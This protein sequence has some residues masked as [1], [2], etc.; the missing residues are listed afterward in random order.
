MKKV[1]ITVDLQKAPKAWTDMSDQEKT[2]EAGRIIDTVADQIDK[3]AQ[4]RSIA[5]IKSSHP[6]S[7]G[8][9]KTIF[10]LATRTRFALDK[11]LMG[12]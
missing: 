1:M 2:A 6:L 9:C 8:R 4:K 3:I 5:K 12:R 10:E 7:V 11:A